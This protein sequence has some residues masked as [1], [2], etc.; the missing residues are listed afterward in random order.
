MMPQSRKRK[1][2][3]QDVASS[4]AGAGAA[5]YPETTDAD[6]ADGGGG[7]RGDGGDGARAKTRSAGD[8]MDETE[9]S[10]PRNKRARTNSEAL[11]EQKKGDGS[12]VNGKNSSLSLAPASRLPK[13]DDDEG[14]G[15][16]GQ[17]APPAVDAVGTRASAR[18]NAA[19]GDVKG[20]GRAGDA[21]TPGNMRRSPLV[22]PGQQQGENL[23]EE[24]RRLEARRR[25]RKARSPY[26]HGGERVDPN[27][28]LPT[29]IRPA[30]VL[31]GLGGK[32]GADG[33]GRRESMI[34][35]ATKTPSKVSVVFSLGGFVLYRVACFFIALCVETMMARCAL[36]VAGM[37]LLPISVA[38]GSGGQ[39]YCSDWR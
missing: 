22:T 15:G 8:S 32:A 26:V 18:R 30:A 36:N 31:G 23:T 5:V 33:G 20:K 9:T 28:G 35:D 11:K 37:F 39:V 34:A 1:P 4:S 24:E 7:S 16:R 12:A 6:G 17:G 19:N 29:S 21:A 3:D 14:G 10:P 13:A 27:A 38:R 25:G 2:V